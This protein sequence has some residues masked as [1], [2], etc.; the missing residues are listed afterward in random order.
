MPAAP[1]FCRPSAVIQSLVQAGLRL[2]R[3]STSS[4]PAPASRRRSSRR[5]SASAGQPVYVGVMVTTT[6]RLRRVTSR[7]MPRSASVSCGSSGSGTASAIA[8]ARAPVL[9]AVTTSLRDGRGQRSGARPADAPRYRG[10]RL[11][12]SHLRAPTTRVAAA[13]LRKAPRRAPRRTRR[14]SRSAG[15]RHRQPASSGLDVRVGEQLADER[16]DMVQARLHPLV[17]ELGA[18]TQADHPLG[19]VVAV[20]GHLFH[21]LVGDGGQHRVA[22][23]P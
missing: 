21:A 17:R 8:R 18:V 10:V 13:W 1:S 15:R 23:C 4:N 6:C 5:I 20:V 16:R 12:S 11:S 22:G 19:G 3:T 9:A 7:R 2:V 14:G